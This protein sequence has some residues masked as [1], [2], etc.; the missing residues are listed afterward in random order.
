MYATGILISE[1]MRRSTSLLAASKGPGRGFI[2][3]YYPPATQ[4][5]LNAAADFRVSVHTLNGI[6]TRL[7]NPEVS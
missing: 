6:S 2:R 4:S 1:R 5:G 7:N 3:Q